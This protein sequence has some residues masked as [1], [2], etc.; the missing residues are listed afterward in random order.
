MTKNDLPRK[1]RPAG[2]KEVLGQP[3]AVRMLT[4]MGKARTIPQCLL[5]VGPS[6][7]GKTTMARVTA[8]K[9]KCGG[10]DLCEVN[11]AEN[12]GIDMVR[13]IAARANMKP[14]AGPVRVWIIDECHQLTADAQGA[15]LKLLEEPPEHVYFMLATTHPNKLRKAILTRCTEIKVNEVGIDLLEGLVQRVHRMETDNN[16]LD[17]AVARKIAECAEG[18]ARTAL[19]LLQTVI[20]I[21]DPDKQLASIENGGAK[22][23][24]IEIARA[25]MKG[26]AWGKMAAILK[27][28][29]EEPESI[30]WLVLSYAT[31]VALGKGDP[32][33]AIDIIEAFGD[34]FYDTKKAGLVRA[35]YDALNQGD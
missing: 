23:Q 17:E 28:C 7:C 35:C 16:D 32:A 10:P 18:S 12:R 33:R 4:A 3:A 6:G 34:N 9:L 1:Y 29:D 2:F 20:N 14:I 24:A 30:R 19:V 25:I 13:S 5:F 8:N 21:T 31:T 15:F 22:A 27:T 26:V 11:A